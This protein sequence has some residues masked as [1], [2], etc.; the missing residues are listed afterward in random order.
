MPDLVVCH[1]RASIDWYVRRS[2][3]GGITM[4]RRESD[5]KNTGNRRF[6]GFI[7]AVAAGIVFVKKKR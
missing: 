1:Q 3:Q 5:I 6:K 2:A 7:A 4:K